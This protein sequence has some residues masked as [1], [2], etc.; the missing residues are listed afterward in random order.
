[1]NWTGHLAKYFI[2][3]GKLT[4]IL[5]LGL[6]V[7]GVISFSLT[8][9][10]YN[11]TIVAPAFKVTVQVPGASR[12]EILEEVTK[13]LENVITDIAGVEDVYSM[14]TKGG[15]AIVYVNFYVGEDLN[16]AKISLNDRLQSDARLAPQGIIGPI[17]ESLDPEDV[18]VVQIA[19]TS[20]KLS[21]VDLRKLGFEIKDQLSSVEGTSRIFVVG[22]Q[23]RELRVEIDPMKLN[24][25]AVSIQQIE[26]A[27][28]QNNIY[29]PSGMIKGKTN[30]IEL[31]TNA[32]VHSPSEVEEIVVVTN[33]SINIKVKD[34]ARVYETEEEIENHVFHQKKDFQTK[35]VL[36][37]VSKLKGTNI[38]DVTDRIVERVNEINKKINQQAHAEVIVNDGNTARDEIGSL[39]TNLLQ[40]VAI[41]IAVLF[42]FLNAKA[43]LLVAISIPLTLATVFGAAFIAGQDINRITLFALILSLGMLVDNATVVI[44]N[45][46]RKV[47]EE[48]KITKDTFAEAVNE[49]GIGLLMSTVTTVLS[50]IPM[51][52]ISGMMGPYM[53]PIP[54]FV[55]AALIFA[56]FISYSINPWM[57]S[58]LITKRDGELAHDRPNHI[59]KWSQLGIEILL[60]YKLMIRHLMMNSVKSKA[61]LIGVMLTLVGVGSFPVFQ[62]VKFRML[63]KANVD[64]F[65]IY[66]DLPQSSSLGETTKAAMLIEQELKKQNEVTMIQTYIGT[67][68]ILDF[69]GL[70]KAVTN[71]QFTHQ[72]TMR[73]GLLPDNQRDLSSE[74][75]VLKIR[76]LLI[77]KLEDIKGAKLKLIEDPPGPPVMSTVQV[78]VQSQNEE[79]MKKEAKALFPILK[80]IK[81]TVDHDTSLPSSSQELNIIIDH[82]EC[83]KSKVSPGQI[84]DTINAFYSGR[85]AGVYHGTNLKEQEY[86]TLRIPKELRFDMEMLK[87]MNI[88]NMMR[89]NIPLSKVAKIEL[90]EASIPLM[91]ENHRNTIYLSSE[92]GNRSVTYAGI[93]LLKELYKYRLSSGD[94]KL[95]SWNLFGMTYETPQHEEVRITIGGEWELTLEVFRDLIL[96][97]AVAIMAIY[98]V[99]VGQFKSFTDALLIMTTIPLS[100]IGIMPG[101][102][103]MGALN[104][105]YFTATSMIGAI[106]LA[107]IAV[108]NAIILLEYI[109]SLKGKGTNIVDALAEA[110]STRLRPIA[111]TTITTILG[112]LTIVS[113]PVWSGLAWAIIWGLGV[114]STLILIVFPLLYHIIHAK[115]WETYR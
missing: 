97:M 39:L 98:L 44:E 52:Y 80:G 86:I 53:G 61:V 105:E 111:L 49:V 102:A 59:S 60:K 63:P 93:D 31:H 48:K 4:G 42:L 88:P 115:K 83:S 45:I 2:D 110:T 34:L 81:K 69:N 6:F 95:K 27:L 113:D 68:P 76:P 91:R 55:P 54:F 12:E 1:M 82:F 100:I 19:L 46:V 17:V 108:N 106:A 77:K 33:D 30:N 23:K 14:T 38:S 21:L 112:S 79:L 37:S 40:S 58:V 78:R 89:I 62:W 57:A 85:I 25:Y 72:A 104:G 84:V 66:L 65:F 51:A 73:V 10:K 22:G 96:A 5:M 101:F 3:N 16:N 29:L 71:R 90:Q 8:P 114:S 20:D 35:S 47:G 87:K 43:S 41:V 94:A 36:I 15:M 99:L 13:P 92:M 64:Q 67:P 18:P 11:P 103:I 56:L 32:W 28:K 9:K 107:G 24:N 70:F 74:E 50:F 75:L 26:S 109:N 7:W